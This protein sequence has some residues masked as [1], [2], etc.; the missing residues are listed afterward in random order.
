MMT[1]ENTPRRV[2]LVQRAQARLARWLLARLPARIACQV[3]ESVLVSRAGDDPRIGAYALECNN[4]QALC[5]LI[6]AY[7]TIQ[8]LLRA[9]PRMGT[10]RLLD[11]GP[12]FGASAGLLWQMHRSHFLGPRLEVE[13]MDIVAT[14]R[15][16]IEM[17]WPW[18]RFLHGRIEA[19]PAQARWDVVYCSNAIEHMEDPRAFI[20]A[21]LEHTGSHAVFMAPWCEEAPMSLDH[22]SRIDEGTFEGFDVESLQLLHSAAW[23]AT[24][25]GRHRQQVLAVLRPKG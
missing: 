16:F 14:R 24:A 8:R 19:L 20:Q 13:A 3:V 9:Q 4:P 7:P 6:D 10:V 23:P 2:T 17:S 22:R 25:D 12:A 1:N 21:V 5:F 15:G 18:V 11:I